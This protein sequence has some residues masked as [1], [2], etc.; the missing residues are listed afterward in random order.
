MVSGMYLRPQIHATQRSI[1]MPE[2]AVR[3]GAVL[4]QIDVPIEGFLRQMMLFDIRDPARTSSWSSRSRSPRR[5]PPS[6][7][8]RL[9]RAR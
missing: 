1:P 4:A 8:S 2:P 3:D 7:D 5:R 9:P 6:I